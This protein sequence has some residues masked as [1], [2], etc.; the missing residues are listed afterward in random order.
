MAHVGDLRGRKQMFTL[1]I[2]LMA[3]PTLG[4]GLL[5]TYAKL[6]IWA[7]V[8]LLLFRTLQGVAVGGEVPGAW[9]FVSEHVN[10]SHVGLRNLNWRSHRRHSPWFIGGQQ[11]KHSDDTRPVG[12]IRL[13]D[14]LR[15]WRRLRFA[16]DVRSSFII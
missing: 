15:A 11:F 6:A 5:P 10:P 9:V 8:L 12:S 4:I 14:S 7:P 3:L 2:F 13:A 1:S 16:G